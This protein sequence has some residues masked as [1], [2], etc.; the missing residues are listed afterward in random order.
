M[1]DQ[2]KVGHHWSAALL[3]QEVDVL[4]ALL[5]AESA[6]FFPFFVWRINDPKCVNLVEPSR[7]QEPNSNCADVLVREGLD[8]TAG[9]SLTKDLLVYSLWLSSTGVGLTYI[10]AR[11]IVWFSVWSL[12][13]ICKLSFNVPV[14]STGG[15]YPSTVHA[16][17]VLSIEVMSQRAPRWNLDL[18]VFTRGPQNKGSVTI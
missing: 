13:A 15:M 6:L 8:E 16:S 11:S 10:K 3:I 18:H 1:W 14:I 7:K 12:D 2:E 17:L 9:A 4:L 5:L